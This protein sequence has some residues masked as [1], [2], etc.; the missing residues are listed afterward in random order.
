MW[1]QKKK[2]EKLGGKGLRFKP[3]LLY[4]LFLIWFGRPEPDAAFFFPLRFQFQF[5]AAEGKV[6]REKYLKRAAGN[7]S[8]RKATSL[9]S[10]GHPG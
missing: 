8:E 2:Q 1:L 4:L 5:E 3:P 10:S 6:L 9:C 7:E